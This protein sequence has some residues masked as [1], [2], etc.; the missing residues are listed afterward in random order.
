MSSQY[1]I[2]LEEYKRI[3][4]IKK[5]LFSNNIPLSIAD[6]LMR[7]GNVYNKLNQPQSGIEHHHKCLEIRKQILHENHPLMAE[8][9]LAIGIDQNKTGEHWDALENL[10]E[11]LKINRKNGP[12]FDNLIAETLLAISNA[13]ENLKFYQ[14]ALE[15]QFE[16]LRIQKTIFHRIAHKTEN[17]EKSENDP[18]KQAV[19]NEAVRIDKS[20]IQT[21]HLAIADTFNSIAMTYS[22]I[23]LN[24]YALENLNQSLLIKKTLRRLLHSMCYTL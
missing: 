6:T 7:I 22:T 8:S 3:L 17:A 13:Y 18:D 23:E 24:E 5:S 20:T 16:A 12:V 21:C 2:A 15:N 4:E 10:N 19:H 14:N 11:S 9:F 1:S